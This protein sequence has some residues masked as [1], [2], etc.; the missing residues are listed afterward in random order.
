MATRCGSEA[1]AD[2][3]AAIMSAIP[4][5]DAFIMPFIGALAI[6]KRSTMRLETGQH[7]LVSSERNGA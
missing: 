3:F 1:E 2:I 5:D 6:R 4:P 7:R